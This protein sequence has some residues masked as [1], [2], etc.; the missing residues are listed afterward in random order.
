GVAFAAAH[1]RAG[2]AS[3]RA[4][5]PLA[6]HATLLGGRGRVSDDPVELGHRLVTSVEPGR[7]DRQ[8]IVQEELVRRLLQGKAAM[9]GRATPIPLVEGLVAL[10]GVIHLGL[11]D[12]RPYRRL[13]ASRDRHRHQGDKRNAGELHVPDTSLN[14]PGLTNQLIGTEPPPL[15]TAGQ[16][17]VTGAFPVSSVSMF[18]DCVSTR[19]VEITAPETWPLPL[20]CRVTS[21]WA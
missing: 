4:G 13:L 9:R 20:P 16:S 11:L 15:L 17:Y 6:S 8:S 14:D 21:F 19:L 10:G 18:V 1:A 12:D 5:Q 3:A 7:G 2:H